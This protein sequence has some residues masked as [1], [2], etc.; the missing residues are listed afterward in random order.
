M[1]LLTS[2]Y[3][4][5][6]GNKWYDRLTLDLFC[7]SQLLYCKTTFFHKVY[8]CEFCDFYINANINRLTSEFS[9]TKLH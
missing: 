1:L 5:T 4:F 8:F 6:K 7:Y 9:F 2:N 3:I